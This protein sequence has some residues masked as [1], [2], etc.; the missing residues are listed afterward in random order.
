M[1]RVSASVSAMRRRSWMKVSTRA[2]GGGV[3]L[4]EVLVGE[5]PA[6]GHVGVAFAFAEGDEAAEDGAEG[7][8]GTRV[9][10]G[11]WA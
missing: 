1:E 7:V 6:V 8:F 2:C 10:V 4:D 5:G 3:A 9:V 11:L